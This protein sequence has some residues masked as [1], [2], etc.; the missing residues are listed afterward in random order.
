MALLTMLALKTVAGGMLRPADQAAGLVRWGWAIPALWGAALASILATLA[1]Y[2]AFG[3]FLVSQ[4]VWASTV[5]ALLHVL[6]IVTDELFSAGLKPDARL[7]RAVGAAMGLSGAAVEQVG[8]AFSGLLRLLLIAVAALLVLVPWGIESGDV[9]GWLQAA[10][11]GVTV[12]QVTISPAAILGG[13]VLFLLGILAT[14]AV[15]RWLDAKLLPRTRLDVGLRTSIRTGVGYVGVLLAA[16]AG[17]GYLGLDLGRL[18][19]VAGA[20][21]VGIGFG[22]QSIVNNFVSGLILLAERPIKAGDW[23]VVGSDQGFVKRINV[24]ATEIETFDRASVIIPNSNL[25]SGVVKNWM[26]A[27]TTGRVVIPVGVA[28]DSDPERVR[29]LLLGCAEDHASVLVYPEP[30][31]FFKNFGESSLAFE[32]I[33]FVGDVTQSAR[34]ASDLHFAIL[35]RLRQDGIEIPFAQRELRLRDIDRLEAIAERLGRPRRSIPV[36][37]PAE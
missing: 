12:G 6:L 1:G 7:V 25:I 14:R 31:V 33:C 28:Y 35:K 32:L 11:I 2:V 26:H 21:S 27:D 3:L 9:L 37:V 19:I 30:R 17:V 22:L 20:L 15:Q 23:I 34:V 36:A 10:V 13:L 29:S 8:I 5:L 16:L 18:A 24:R 4:I